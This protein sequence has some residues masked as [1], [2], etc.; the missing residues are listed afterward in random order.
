M[1]VGPWNEEHIRIS[2][3]CYRLSG[4]HGERRDGLMPSK[5]PMRGGPFDRRDLATDQGFNTAL[6]IGQRL[7]GGLAAQPGGLKFLVDNV[8]EL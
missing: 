4:P 5:N 2:H 6:G 7:L 8:L 3:R 1:A